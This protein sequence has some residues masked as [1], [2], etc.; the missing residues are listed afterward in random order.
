MPPMTSAEKSG[1]ISWTVQFMGTPD[2]AR[3]F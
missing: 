1:T 3:F 2:S